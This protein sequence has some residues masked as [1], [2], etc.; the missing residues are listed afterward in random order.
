VSNR[1]M[2]RLPGGGHVS[3]GALQETRAKTVAHAAW[4][5]KMQPLVDAMLAAT[6]SGDTDE[7]ARLA[8]EAKA[9]G[10][11]PMKGI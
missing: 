3:A 4:N 5:A 10:P 2:T 7:V 11:D 8:A 6:L 1:N 9:L